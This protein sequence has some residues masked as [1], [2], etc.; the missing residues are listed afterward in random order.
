MVP[1]LFVLFAKKHPA[2]VHVPLGLALCLPLL[3]LAGFR[4][5]HAASC[6]RV[7]SGLALLALAASGLTLLS[8]LGWA[9]LL[10]L[11]PPGGFLPQVGTQGQALQHTLRLHELTALGGLGWGLLCLLLLRG[12]GRA[13][14]D[15]HWAAACLAGTLAWAVTWGAAGRLGGIMV[16]G[17]AD[18]N[19][20]AAQAIEARKNDA[21]AELP[22][23]ALDYASLEPLRAVPFRSRTHGG[24][25]ARTWV[26]A[27]GLDDLAKG[28]PLP[29]G[30][31]AVMSTV[32]DASGTP[33]P[34]YLR[35]TKADGS[36]AFAFYWP[37][38]PETSR[39]DTGGEDFVYWRSP[40][41]ALVACTTCHH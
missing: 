40:H 16:Y 32:L 34:L 10:S 21:E 26:T 5:R 7:A 4:S 27:S 25:L 1:E 8:G 29:T 12:L 18:T 14:G 28:R 2:L 41:P 31:Y 33:G 17:N 37:R 19:R 9:R 13:P 30:A 6:A 23:R 39:R 3:V 24:R 38:V 15:R 11:V 22:I 36:Q 35:E 20:M